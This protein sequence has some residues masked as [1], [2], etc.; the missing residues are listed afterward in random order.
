M[1]DNIETDLDITNGARGEIV[2][3]VMHPKELRIN[4][5]ASVV[6]LKYLSSYIH[7]KM[8]RTRA[9]KL[10]GLDECIIPIESTSTTYRIQ[11]PIG[12]KLMRRTITRKQ[13]SITAAYAFTDYWSQG[14]TCTICH[15]GQSKTTNKRTQPFQFVCGIVAKS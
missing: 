5:D 3:I 4:K 14:Q 7:V 2:D 8:S 6:R 9:T 13:Y 1:K 10:E 15:C 11:V 12:G